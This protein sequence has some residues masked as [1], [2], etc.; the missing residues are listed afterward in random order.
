MTPITCIILAKNEAHRIAPVIA[1]A[2]TWCDEVMVACK[3]STDG[4]E[5]L[6]EKCGAK[7]HRLPDSAQGMERGEEVT[8]GATHDWVLILTAGEIPTPSLARV[9]PQLVTEHGEQYDAFILFFKY[10]SFGIHTPASPWSWSGQIRLM[11]R[12]RVHFKNKVHDSFH[13][14]PGRTGQLDGAMREELHIL[15]QTHPTCA[16]FMRS[17]LDYMRAEAAA[18]PA[19]RLAN[20]RAQL[21]MMDKREGVPEIH[22]FAWAT[23]WNGVALHCLEA[24]NNGRVLDQYA[25][26]RTEYLTALAQTSV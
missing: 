9:I 23:Y 12:K 8:A 21:A 6:V 18:G 13:T 15:H 2:K 26:R 4:T 1:A 14:E 17:H 20:A 16:D 19:E 7:L 24:L 3:P 22:R 5:A 11:N 10:W 25:E